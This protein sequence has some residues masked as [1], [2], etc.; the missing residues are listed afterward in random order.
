MLMTRITLIL[1]TGLSTHE[2]FTIETRFLCGV[3]RTPKKIDILKN[4]RCITRKVN[5]WYTRFQAVI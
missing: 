1:M 2:R 4:V 3:R 5:T